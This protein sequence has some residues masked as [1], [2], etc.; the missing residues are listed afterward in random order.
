MENRSNT[1]SSGI[2][3]SGLDRSILDQLYQLGG[4]TGT[5]VCS[6]IDAFRRS[7]PDYMDELRAGVASGNADE[8]R[9]AAHAMKSSAANLGATE[10]SSQCET[11]EH[12]AR[13]GNLDTVADDMAS[14]ERLLPLA[15]AALDA[16]YT[17]ASGKN[18]A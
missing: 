14:V 13:E 16:E 7:I 18:A 9:M 6:V 3:S 11:I 15:M 17:A 4:G 1:G 12:H 8:I 2:E 5:L 10:F